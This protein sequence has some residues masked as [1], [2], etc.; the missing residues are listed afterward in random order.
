M[1]HARPWTALWAI[2]PILIGLSPGSSRAGAPA[3][4]TASS[5]LVS[6]VWRHHKAAFDYGGFTSLY[7]CDGLESHVLDILRHLGA[8]KDIRVSATGCPGPSNTPSRTARVDAEF[9]SLAP[10]PAASALDAVKARWTALE[11][12]P[13][14]P[15]FM[16]DGDCELVQAMKDL[17]TQNF[18]LRDLEYRTNC[19]PHE[20][21]LDSFAIKGQVFKAVP[22]N[23]MG[24]KG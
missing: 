12:T 23:S 15:A 10:L 16:G 17:I 5:D 13:R 4:D 18:S 1:R 19:V 22:S 14:R 20:L 9:S 8:R 2:L 24:V 11:V 6:G 21:L 3:A 7:T